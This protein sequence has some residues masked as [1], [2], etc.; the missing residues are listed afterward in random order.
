MQTP[1]PIRLGVI[2]KDDMRLMIVAVNIVLELIKLADLREFVA[3]SY[4]F[5]YLEF[6]VSGA[7]NDIGCFQAAGLWD[8]TLEHQGAHRKGRW[9][10]A[11]GGFTLGTPRFVREKQ[12]PDKLTSGGTSIISLSWLY[13]RF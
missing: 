3:P 10:V 7:A 6:S 12:S 4:E 1:L 5:Q 13:G 2:A 11:Q 8:C 9:D